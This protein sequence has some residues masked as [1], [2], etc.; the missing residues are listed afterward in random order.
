MNIQKSKVQN[1][2]GSFWQS[3]GSVL[4]LPISVFVYLI[5]TDFHIA[6]LTSQALRSQTCITTLPGEPGG[7]CPF[8]TQAIHLI[9][10]QN[11]VRQF[12]YR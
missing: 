2:M 11:S 8:L 9:Q 5:Q 4:D 3:Q 7:F 10:L 12:E 6:P 1:H